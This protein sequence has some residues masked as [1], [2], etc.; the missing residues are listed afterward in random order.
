[1]G[2]KSVH[3]Y[4]KYAI[5]PI[6]CIFL[7]II[8]EVFKSGAFQTQPMG[9]G[10]TEA[11][12]VLS[13][14]SA[15]TGFGIGWAA[16][17]ADYNVMQPETR[18][19]WKV[20]FATWAG[21]L[22]ALLFVQ[23]IGVASAMAVLSTPRFRD[24]YGT[25]SIGGLVGEILKPLSGC[26]Q[27]L[28]LALLA[29]SIISNNVPNNYSFALSMQV[30]GGPFLKTPRWL[31]TIVGGLVYIALAIPG[32]TRFETALENLLNMTAYWLSIYT[33]IIT[34]EHFI[35]RQGGSGYHLD[36]WNDRSRLPIG[37]AAL[38]ALCCGI[39]GAI[40]GMNQAWYTGIIAKHIGKNGGDIGFELAA[41]Y[42]VTDDH[43]T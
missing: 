20:F 42:D 26:L 11:G 13:F 5:I 23:F 19:P 2:Y 43:T 8:V 36:N 10:I 41:M 25:N 30:F 27:K 34:E 1:M 4:E 35:F 40:L 39:F 37:F 15:I 16:F 21:I 18:D 38:L 9:T 24:A 7:F 6:F 17:A 32:S 31:W 28:S 29:F 12:D 3:T 14:G 33:V 22:A